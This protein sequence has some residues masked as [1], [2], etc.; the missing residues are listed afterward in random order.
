MW[1][2]ILADLNAYAE[3]PL[4][5]MLDSTTVRVHQHGTGAKKGAKPRMPGRAVSGANDRPTIRLLVDPEE[6]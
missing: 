6:D 5:I 2:K 1:E 4:Q 3:V